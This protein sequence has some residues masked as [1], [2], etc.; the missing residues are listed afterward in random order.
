MVKVGLIVNPIAGI[1]AKL[2]WKGTDNIEK[3]WN[4]ILEGNPSESLKVAEKALKS[5]QSGN[6]QWL[7]TNEEF[8][9]LGR[10]IYQMPIKSGPEHTKEATRRLIKEQVDL[11]VF[12]GGDGTAADIAELTY[13]A[14]I[15]IIGIPAGVKI[16]SGAFLHNPEDLGDFLKEWTGE[17]KVVEIEDLDEDAYRKGEIIPKVIHAAY[18]PAF[19]RVK[20]GKST[21]H[22]SGNLEI[23]K[24][25]A[26]RIVEENLLEGTI[27]VGGGSTLSEIFAAL[28]L[29]KSLLGVDVFQDGVRTWV[30]ANYEVLQEVEA[31]EIWLTPIGQQG[32]LFGRGNRQIPPSLIRKVGKKG[33]RIFATPE[34]MAN[35]PILYIDTGDSDLDEELKGYYKV[36][37]GYHES[38]VRKVE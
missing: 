37:V 25:I 38:V 31:K 34:K 27:V 12:V 13:S 9:E 11:I 21:F 7:I 18:V 26:Q 14:R 19:G 36:I 5:V 35:T 10:V 30:D 28:D 29:E 3:A 32:H 24:G 16:F 4:I 20:E 17:V 6:L 33:I 1:G 22:S 2:A 23:F 15:P 8:K